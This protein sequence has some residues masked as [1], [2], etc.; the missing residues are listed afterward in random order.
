MKIVQIL[1]PEHKKTII[2]LPW[3]GLDVSID[4]NWLMNFKRKFKK[5]EWMWHTQYL[6]LIDQYYLWLLWLRFVLSI[7][8]IDS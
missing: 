6:I 7:I 4:N 1:D 3:Y 5:H 2:N 8:I